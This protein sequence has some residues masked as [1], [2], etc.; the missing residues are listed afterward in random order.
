MIYLTFKCAVKSRVDF[1]SPDISSSSCTLCIMW[2]CLHSLSP[3][4]S[5]STLPTLLPVQGSEGG[6]S[7]RSYFQLHPTLRGCIMRFA[8]Q[9]MYNHKMQRCRLNESSGVYTLLSDW[10]FCSFCGDA[11]NLQHHTFSVAMPLS[12]GHPDQIKG[13][14]EELLITVLVFDINLISI[15]LPMWGQTLGHLWYQISTRPIC[16]YFGVTIHVAT[17]I[18]FL[19]IVCI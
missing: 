1:P 14:N 9:H 3:T 10:L 13:G 18:N 2:S 15:W 5:A 7:I 17:S 12:V 6:P 4:P 19:V 16:D 11:K 8:F